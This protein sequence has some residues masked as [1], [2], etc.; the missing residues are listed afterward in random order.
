LT[1]RV[2]HTGRQFLDQANRL[3]LP[4][5]TRFDFGARYHTRVA[6]KPVVFR[7]NLENA[8]DKA[9]WG[10][11]NAG[12]LYVGAPRTLLLSATVDF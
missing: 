7:A 10:A 2:I 4:N 8:F 1:S 6:G 5:W 3:R 11:A 12:Y 9:Y